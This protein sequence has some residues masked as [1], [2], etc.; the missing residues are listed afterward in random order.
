MRWTVKHGDIL[1]E[2]A[3]VLVCSSNVYLNLSGGVGGEILLRYGNAMQVELHRF[4]ADRGLRFAN[5]GDVVAASSCG[6][7]FKCVLH[8]VAVDAFYASSVALVR[9][10]VHRALEMAASIHARRVALTALATGYGRLSM[11][12]F[13][14]A[15][16]PLA[17]LRLSPTEDVIICV[18][19]KRDAQE[20]ASALQEDEGGY[21]GPL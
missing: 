20:L 19:S 14:D 13:A 10:T 2:S 12:D 15:I 8:A 9:S 18:S 3:D 1:A 6:T 4:L 21:I 16:R 7:P 11:T 17:S 5:P